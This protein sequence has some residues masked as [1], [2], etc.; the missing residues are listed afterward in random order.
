VGLAIFGL[1]PEAIL[2]E[3]VGV[4]YVD[5]WLKLRC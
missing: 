3:D 5:D 1:I 2:A 4:L